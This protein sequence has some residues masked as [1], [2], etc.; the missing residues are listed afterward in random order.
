VGWAGASRACR[1]RVARVSRGQLAWGSTR[2]SHQP[3]RSLFRPGAGRR[4]TESGV[5]KPDGAVRPE[6][7]AAQQ[8]SG[9]DRTKRSR[10]D[11]YYPPKCLSTLGRKRSVFRR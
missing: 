10:G 7:L 8:T 4:D 3:W 1:E 11:L 5:L 6:R 2:A 9:S